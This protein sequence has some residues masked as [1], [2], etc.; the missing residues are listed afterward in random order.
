LGADSFVQSDVAAFSRHPQSLG[1][2]H[3]GQRLPVR[4]VQG[5]VS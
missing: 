1:E 4:G 3:C 2:E 5:I